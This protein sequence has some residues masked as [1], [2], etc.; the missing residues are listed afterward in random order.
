MTS[1]GGELG[2]MG[3]LLGG[4]GELSEWFGQYGDSWVILC[5]QGY[6]YNP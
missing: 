4:S 1:V 6:T 2:L 5:L 3:E